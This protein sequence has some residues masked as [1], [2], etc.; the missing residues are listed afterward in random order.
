M[1]SKTPHP[2]FEQFVRSS[3]QQLG[4]LAPTEVRDLADVELV[5]ESPRR[6]PRRR[7]AAITGAVVALTGGLTLTGIVA[8]GGE[9]GGGNTPEDAVLEFVEAIENRDV[10][11]ALD[12]IDPGES[13]ALINTVTALVEESTR[14]GL[15]SDAI[16]TTDV[17]GAAAGIDGLQLSTDQVATDLAVVTADG[18]T[19][20][21][22]IDLNAL[23]LGAGLADQV[24]PEDGE[25]AFIDFA[26]DPLSVATVERDGR[27]YVSFS[28][29]IAEAVRRDAGLPFPVAAPPSGDGFDDPGAAAAAFWTHAASLDLTSA[30]ATFA[31]GEADAISRYVPLWSASI[32][33][34][35]AD[36]EASGFEISIA[37][38]E[39]DITPD[40]NRS[41]VEPSAFVIEG[42]LP[43]MTDEGLPPFDP[44]AETIIY[45]DDGS[46]FYVIEA[47]DPIPDSFDGLEPTEQFPDDIGSDGTALNGAVLMEDG[48]IEG[49]WSDEAP[50]DDLTP[51]PFRVELAAGC[52]ITSGAIADDVLISS[53]EPVGVEDLGDGR[54]RS[55]ATDT[56]T[57]GSGVLGLVVFG[58][59]GVF[60][61]SLPS[62]ET[63][64]I[65]GRWYVSPIGTLGV[66][67][68]DILADVE[69][70][71]ILSLDSPLAA[72][73]YGVDGPTVESRLVGRPESG[74]GPECAP[75]VLVD[76]AGIVTAISDDAGLD[77]V[78]ACTESEDF[79]SGPLVDAPD[80]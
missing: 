34:T 77:G 80:D 33:A 53:S 47:G 63:V 52:T 24:N 54:F 29:S 3:L 48:T 13:D 39:F 41:L 71:R 65:D 16:D 31:P 51:R 4:D 78:R 45:T 19:A 42:A 30:I 64:E 27:W 74:I 76:D 79:W 23:P 5:A 14:I 73:F 57:S 46:G 7:I 68:L 58:R 59:G 8:T 12:V 43:A 17:P 72:F 44:D 26:D 69:D 20:E 9:D 28:Y 61:L 37:D 22:S 40:G 49:F 35:L 1:T 32:D 50:D 25:L 75:I 62:V 70:D 21:L 2:D 38:I 55:C 15:F 6:T 11:G 36:A 10:I 60:N 66:Q 18:G 67:I 56:A